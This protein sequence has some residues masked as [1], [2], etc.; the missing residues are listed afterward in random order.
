M[1]WRTGGDSC[2]WAPLPPHAD[3]DARLGWRFNGVRVAANFDFGLGINAFA[4][5]SFGDFCNHDLPRRCLPPARVTTVYRQTTVINNYVVNNNTVVHRGIPL[6][7]VTAAS[8]VAVPRATV[9]DWPRRV[10]PHTGPERG[11]GVSAASPGSGTTGADGGPESG[12]AAPGDP[13]RLARTRTDGP[14]IRAGSKRL[15]PGGHAAGAD[16][17][18]AQALASVERHK[19]GLHRAASV[20]RAGCSASNDRARDPDLEPAD[21]EL[22]TRGNGETRLPL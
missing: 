21:P 5:V 11:G 7:R 3:F 13:A 10:G 19:I 6:E 16:R 2:G 20:G 12:H 4:F 1:T 15:G 17:R 18:N 8:R 14:H 9:H 22:E